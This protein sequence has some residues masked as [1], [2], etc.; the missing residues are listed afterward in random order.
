LL[1][2]L[3]SAATPAPETFAMSVAPV[4]KWASCGRQSRGR[5]R[6]S[7]RVVK[8]I[9]RTGAVKQDPVSVVE[10][11]IAGA[12]RGPGRHWKSDRMAAGLRLC[13]IDQPVPRSTVPPVPYFLKF[14]CQSLWRRD[15]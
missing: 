7:I 8:L 1:P 2:P 6:R 11:P 12:R 10:N 15:T 13:V 5:N 3:D 14:T 9:H 4:V